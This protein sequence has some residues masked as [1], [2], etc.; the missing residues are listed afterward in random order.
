MIYELSKGETPFAATP[1]IRMYQ[2]IISN[3]YTIPLH[4]T[5]PLKVTNKSKM[6]GE[7]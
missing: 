5:A 3:H 6:N 7:K 1:V 4:F 2:K